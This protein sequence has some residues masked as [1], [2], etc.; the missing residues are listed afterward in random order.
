MVC[1]FS[2]LEY[3]PVTHGVTGSSPVHTAHSIHFG[4]LTEWL[5]SGL[6]NRVQQFESAGYLNKKSKLSFES[7][8]F[9]FSNTFACINWNLQPLPQ[10]SPTRDRGFL[11][12]HIYPHN[13]LQSPI[14]QGNIN[15]NNIA[16]ERIGKPRTEYNV[17]HLPCENIRNAYTS[18]TYRTFFAAYFYKRLN[19]VLYR[20][21]ISNNPKLFHQLWTSFAKQ[22]LTQNFNGLRI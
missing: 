17:L 2:W 1:Q 21:V 5:G 12:L 22:S 13:S 9:L 20:S 10:P 19:N 18:V 15:T 14:Q 7:L 6:Q 4:T 16:L 3:M 11:I 8:L